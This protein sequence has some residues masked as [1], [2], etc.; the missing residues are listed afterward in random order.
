M[1]LEPSI[2]RDREISTDRLLELETALLKFTEFFGDAEIVT[3]EDIE[4]VIV[5]R[6]AEF[7]QLLEHLGQAVNL[8]GSS[9]DDLLNIVFNNDVNDLNN[10]FYRI[11]GLVDHDIK[12][13]FI[14]IKSYVDMASWSI[15]D[16]EIS[17]DE[18]GYLSLYIPSIL[19]SSKEALHMIQVLKKYREGGARINIYE[20]PEA[21]GFVKKE[22]RQGVHTYEIRAEEELTVLH[23]ESNATIDSPEILFTISTLILNAKNARVPNIYVRITK[24]D[25]ELILEVLDDGTG[26]VFPDT[27][28]NDIQSFFRRGMNEPTRELNENAGGGKLAAFLSGQRYALMNPLRMPGYYSEDFELINIDIPSEEQGQPPRLAKGFRI[29]VRDD[30]TYNKLSNLGINYHLTHI[31]QLQEI[32][33]SGE[34]VRALESVGSYFNFFVQNIDSE[35]GFVRLVI[36]NTQNSTIHNLEQQIIE[37]LKQYTASVI[38]KLNIG[39]TPQDIDI[40]NFIKF[41]NLVLSVGTSQDPV[42]EDE[43]LTLLN[44]SKEDFID[45]AA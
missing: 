29:R 21:I 13:A 17:T 43:L 28:V 44:V 10:P 32:V 1:S 39:E 37:K 42:L 12:K 20:Y 40:T 38:E 31:E 36:A 14:L 11:K 9:T 15:L 5:P 4:R 45:D 18:Y 41:C 23:I 2:D 26:G 3:T 25:E 34:Y 19:K 22:E 16:G 8:F 33:Q 7:A 27:Y 6:T 35:D 24:Q 30:I